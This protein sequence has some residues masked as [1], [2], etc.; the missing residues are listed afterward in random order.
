MKQ[1]SYIF[2]LFSI[3]LFSQTG[4]EDVYTFLNMPTSARQ[5]ALGGS[6]LTLTNEVNQPLWNPATLTAEMDQMLTLN[7]VN[8]LADINYF[9]GSYAYHFNDH[10]GNL[11]TGLT[12]LNYGKFI[13]ADEEGNETGTFKAYDMALSVGYSYQFPYTDF[14]MGANAKFIHSVIEDYQSIGLAADIGFMFKPEDAP[15]TVGIVVRNMGSQIVT[16]NGTKESLPLLIQAGWSYQLEH[17]P[18]RIYTT[19]DNL[20]K[21]QLAYTNPSENTQ[22]LATGEVIE[23]KPGFMD[24]AMRHVVLGAELFPDKGFSLRLGYNYQRSQELKLEG[25]RTFAGLSFGF[26]LKVKKLNLNYAFSKYHPASNS[27]NFSLGINLN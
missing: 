26:G 9:S 21:W 23:N 8:F 2:I 19:F 22:D 4:G 6:T 24:N 18:I 20:Q 13:A 12:Y 15:Y 10:F 11:H 25:T 1:I 14:Y 7:Y 3:S 27:H 16:Y 17:V 5:S